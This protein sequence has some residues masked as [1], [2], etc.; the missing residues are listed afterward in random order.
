MQQPPTAPAAATAPDDHELARRFFERNDR[1][2][3]EDL[4]S[5]HADI[6]YRLALR[7]AGNEADAE[8]LVQRAFVEV[9]Q[10]RSR[11]R[12]DSQFRTWLL[13]VVVN[14]GRTWQREEK[15][16]KRR[17]ELA[18]QMREES[19]QAVADVESEAALRR[20][21]VSLVKALPDRYRLPVW[22]HYF[23]G[24]TFREIAGALNQPEG[25]VR[26]QAS[27]GLDVLR[28]RLGAAGFQA[29]AALLPGLLA[30]APLECAPA[31]LLSA[32]KGLTASG[33][34][35]AS[36]AAGKLSGAA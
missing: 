34:A 27:R 19:P 15:R 5:R 20:A 21:A 31:T 24:L 22:M 18:V 10:A 7:I 8:E 26:S 4:L 28:E 11:F 23:E 12:G 16:R 25:T 9:V 3:L 33:A 6:A 14:C 36:A 30:A 2:A 29:S 32:L 17:E 1:A 35:G 13:G